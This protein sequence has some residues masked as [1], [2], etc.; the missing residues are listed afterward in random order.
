M[1]RRNKKPIAIFILLIIML[2]IVTIWIIQV[3]PLAIFIILG[4]ALI[5]VIIIIIVVAKNDKKKTS[6][7]ESKYIKKRHYL[8]NTEIE[9]YEAIKEII[10]DNY[11][12]LPQIPLSQIVEKENK[13]KY[14][15]EL[16]R[17][18]DICIFDKEYT[19]LLCIE[20]NDETHHLK[21]RYMR[22]IKVKEILNKGGLPLITLW[23]IYGVNPEYIKKRINEHIKLY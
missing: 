4:I 16:Y 7:E 9:F 22:D 6:P 10:Q 20:I 13:N 1:N 2:L 17:V 12:V 23:T 21:D 19:P 15:N 11:I 14:Q 3:N 5:T 18:I 8:T